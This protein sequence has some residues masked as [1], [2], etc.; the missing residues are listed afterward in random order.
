MDEMDVGFDGSEFSDEIYSHIDAFGNFLIDP[1]K[2]WLK[3]AVRVVALDIEPSKYGQQKSLALEILQ[4]ASLTIQNIVTAP[5]AFLGFL[6]GSAIC[7]LVS[8]AKKDITIHSPK[9]EI[10]TDLTASTIRVIS[11]NTLLM[12]DFI[13]VRNKHRPSSERLE[14][15]AELL[16]KKD[17]EVICLQEVFDPNLA[18]ELSLRLS[19]AGYYVARELSSSAVSLNSGL[20]IASKYPIKNPQF[21]P[22]SVCFG[23]D[24]MAGKGVLTVDIALSDKIITIANTHL[25]GG[26][27]EENLASYHAR[28]IQAYEMNQFLEQKGSNA[29]IVAGDMNVSPV[30]QGTFDPEYYIA[31]RLYSEA[32]DSK[33]ALIEKIQKSYEEIVDSYLSFKVLHESAR[34]EEYTQQF[35]NSGGCLPA[36]LYHCGIIDYQR[37]IEGTAVEMD[38]SQSGWNPYE[39]VVKDA[40]LDQVYVRKDRGLAILDEQLDPMFD[41]L[42]LILSDHLALDVT[43]GL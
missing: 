36:H 25:N 16:I 22:H 30:S 34:L 13:A 5:F 35:I 42:G 8:F 4:R 26:G 33:Q 28:M 15:I 7:S 3:R 21:K 6:F 23:A 12:P 24:K 39:C 40:R 38:C 32:L 18:R 2:E 1:A 41:S 20:L 11:Y 43:I 27:S 29:I 14:E 37:A 17:A 9:N 10:T 31:S 19:S